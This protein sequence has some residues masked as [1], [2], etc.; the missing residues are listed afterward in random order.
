MMGDRICGLM[1]ARDEETCVGLTLDTCHQWLDELV[2]VDNSSIDRTAEIV[3]E[4]CARYAI[5]LYEYSAPTTFTVEMLREY[6]LKNGLELDPDW[7]FVV[8]ADIAYNCEK[9]DIRRAVR[10]GKY[11]QYHFKVLNLYG[12]IEHEYIN[13]L[14]EP[15]LFLFRNRREGMYAMTGYC[16]D[17]TYSKCPDFPFLGWNLTGMKPLERLFWRQQLWYARAWNGHYGT[18]YGADEFI[19]HYFFPPPTHAYK[20][21]FIYWLL[22]DANIPLS[23]MAG[24]HYMTAAQFRAKYMDYPAVMR[25]WECPFEIII[26]PDGKFAGRKPDMIGMIVLPREAIYQYTPKVQALFKSYFQEY[27]S[28]KQPIKIC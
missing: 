13:N 5:P 23:T 15:E 22:R 17:H 6:S 11:D 26:G 7:F 21:N 20:E 4:R 12:D 14:N 25:R 28:K 10:D 2:F 18:N 16:M 9:V 27:L 19:D 1:I 24:Y 8:S 3:R